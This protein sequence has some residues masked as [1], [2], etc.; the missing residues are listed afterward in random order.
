MGDLVFK[1]IYYEGFDYDVWYL[2]QLIVEQGSGGMIGYL[3]IKDSDWS[4]RLF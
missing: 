4:Q 2:G 1:V 3:G